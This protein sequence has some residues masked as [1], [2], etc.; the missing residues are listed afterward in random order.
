MLS[1]LCV[2]RFTMEEGNSEV[3]ARL[4]Q[5]DQETQMKQ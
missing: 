5:M 1:F 4:L 3:L 2:C